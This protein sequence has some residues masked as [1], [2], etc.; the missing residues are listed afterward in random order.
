[1]HEY[2]SANWTDKDTRW[3]NSETRC[4]LTECCATNVDGRHTT[5]EVGTLRQIDT[6]EEL[7]RE[8]GSLV[9]KDADGCYAE[10]WPESSINNPYLYWFG[11][12]MTIG[13]GALEYP[14]TVVDEKKED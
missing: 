12:E 7:A 2:S 1:M 6:A 5:N 11:N 10:Y 9:L 4:R 8:L 13:L 3:C 14:V